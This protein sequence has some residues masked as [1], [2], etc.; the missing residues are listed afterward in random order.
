MGSQP[1]EAD[2]ELV[3]GYDLIAHLVPAG[4]PRAAYRPADA[5][6]LPPEAYQAITEKVGRVGLEDLLVIPAMAWPA[7]LRRCLYS[8]LCVAGIGERGVGLWVQAPPVPGVRI[9]VPFGGIAAIEQHRHQSRGLVVVRGGTSSL[10]VRHDADGQAA[11]DAWTR[12][13]RLRAAAV[14]EP[15]PPPR[16]RGPRGG[17]PRGGDGGGS[18][19]LAPDDTIVSAGWRSR[20]GRGSCLVSVT[21]RELIV[22]QSPRDPL[23][24]Q[25]TTCT[26]YVA[27]GSIE[28]AILR[29]KTIL[30]RTAG[31]DVPIALQSRAITAAA[32]D[33]LRWMISEHGYLGS[34][35]PPR[36]GGHGNGKRQ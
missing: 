33:W 4:H 8:P 22:V 18:L 9:Q 7:G 17:G 29:P 34:G 28:G 12:R 32:A 2:W 10:L 3:V 26:L 24:R 23:T 13:L 36:T 21:S 15:V 31:R 11:V 27:R 35:G 25:R 20:A 16:G 5:A 1:E 6:W 19:L 30:L 14:P